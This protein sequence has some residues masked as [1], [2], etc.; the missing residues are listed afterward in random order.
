MRK[1]FRDILERVEHYRDQGGEKQYVLDDAR[2]GRDSQAGEFTPAES[3]ALTGECETMLILYHIDGTERNFRR[4]HPF[5]IKHEL[6]YQGV[7]HRHDYIEILYVIEGSFD[8]IL[9]GKQLHFEQGEFVIT[10]QNCEHADILLP[11]EAS[12]L[13]IQISAEYMRQLLHNYDQDDL[14]ERF[15]F[16]ALRR[17]K[18][19]QRFLELRPDPTQ[20]EEELDLF[21]LLEEIYSEAN[22]QL[23]GQNEVISGLMHRLL[24]HLCTRYTPILHS[25]DQEAKESMVLYELERYILKKYASVTSG[26]LEQVFHYHRNYYN[27][28][29]KKHY[30]KSFKEYL[31]DVRLEKAAELLREHPELTVKKVAQS[32]GYENTSH[33]YHLFREKYGMGPKEMA[34]QTNQ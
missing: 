28:L 19:E 34:G 4:G 13:F 5:I 22:T 24:N 6:P 15:L 3:R 29:L 2:I 33:F 26:E 18:K 1:H 8:Q 14:L 16:R 17:H 27:L 10:D 30:G 23:S 20:D 32:V 31:S 7:M 21:H 9:M 12:V 25:N 11:V